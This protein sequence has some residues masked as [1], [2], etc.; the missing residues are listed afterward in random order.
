[1]G[2]MAQSLNTVVDGL[3]KVTEFAENIGAGNYDY[4]FN[5]LSQND[6]LGQA[7]I[8]MRNSLKK[9]KQEEELR[10][11]QENQLEWT[12]HGMNIFNKV[13]RVDERNLE[14]LSYDII[15]TLTT[16]LEAHMGGIFVKTDI[17]ETEFELISF[18]GFN[19]EK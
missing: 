11:V 17:G 9:A 13:L 15:K 3:N 10:K 12:S 19:K 14:E 8:E 16:Y 18:I 6:V 4:Q 1:M 2:V 7:V 5:K